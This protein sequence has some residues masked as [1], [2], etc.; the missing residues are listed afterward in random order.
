MVARAARPMR[1]SRANTTTMQQ[2]GATTLDVTSGMKCAMESSSFET[3]S[4]MRVLKSPAGVSSKTPK[5][6]RNIFSAI[7]LRMF[8][9][10][11][12]VALCDIRVETKVKAS[13]SS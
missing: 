5:G 11:R 8:F 1:Q 3:V 9:R 6:T 7:A 13:L 4:T 12:Y 10:I 2:N